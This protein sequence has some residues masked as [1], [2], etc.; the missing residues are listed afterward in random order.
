M[1]ALFIPA[2]SVSAAKKDT[3]IINVEQDYKLSQEVLKKVNKERKKRG[4]KVLKMDRTLSKHAITRAAELCVMVPFESPHKRPNGKQNS[5]TH[6]VIYECAMEQINGS[7]DADEIVSTWMGSPSHKKGI[8]LPEARSVGV[9]CVRVGVNCNYVLE[10]SPR[11]VRK[12]QKLKT[13]KNYSIKVK[14]LRKYL[15]KKAFSIEALDY[16]GIDGPGSKCIIRMTTGRSVATYVVSQRNFKWKS[17]KPSIVSVSK[18]GQITSKKPG[19][20]TITATYKSNPK[21]KLKVSYKAWLP[22]I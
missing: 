20:V 1:I 13:K 4:L 22:G 14:A 8:L 17:S 11:T 19:T 18:D 12:V 16:R 9:A 5:G 6:G 7:L 3:I 10:F 15:P 21:I 2:T